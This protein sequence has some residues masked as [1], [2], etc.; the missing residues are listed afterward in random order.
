MST[1]AL[2]LHAGYR[3]RSSGECCET[4]AVPAEPHVLHVVQA[5]QIRRTGFHGALFV[6]AASPR[7]DAPWTTA[8]DEHGGCAFFDR[9]GG[10][11][12]AIHAAAGPDAMPGACRHFPRTILRD[13]RGTHIS[14]S[15]FCPTAAALLF[16]PVRLAIVEVGPPLR[17][18]EPIE[19]MDAARAL[20]PLLRPGVLTDME[21]YAAWEH[22][23]VGV[24]A[25][26]DLRYQQALAVIASATERVRRW[27]P[28]TSPLSYAVED[29]FERTRSQPSTDSLDQSR[30]MRI[31]RAISPTGAQADLVHVEPFEQDWQRL[32]AWSFA[33]FD[34]PMKNFLAAR[35]FGA[36]IAYQGQGLRSIVEWIRTCAALVRHFALQQARVTQSAPGLHEMVEAFRKTDLLLLHGADSQAFAREVLAIE[37]R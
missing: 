32:V 6:E 17:P 22:A 13:A 16:E 5:R 3:C 4:W 1:F 24:L 34:R 23:S 33:A 9:T 21:G 15:H 27:Q 28:G 8:R 29:A 26:P 37:G 25:R 30:A 19:G 11:L 35:L 18:S 31:L 14:L 12:C 36:W 2:T 20:P 7:S 10:R